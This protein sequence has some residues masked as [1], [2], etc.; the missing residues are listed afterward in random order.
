[1]RDAVRMLRILNVMSPKDGENL[2]FDDFERLS[3]FRVDR[4][5][6]NSVAPAANATWR[7][8]ESVELA[9]GDNVGVVTPWDLPAS[10]SPDDQDKADKLFLQL[11]DQY[12]ASGREVNDRHHRYY[13]PKCFAEEAVARAARISRAKFEAAM[14]RLL[15]AGK[16]RVDVYGRA[17]R[18]FSRIVRTQPGDNVVPFSRPDTD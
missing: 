12:N 11:L 6:A 17:D 5:K 2:G 18:P 7:K 8:F 1:M 9:N 4:G 3:Y 13:A 16:I 14:E 15:A 10:E